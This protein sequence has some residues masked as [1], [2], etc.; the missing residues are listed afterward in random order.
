[1]KP[2]F[3]ELQWFRLANSTP[4]P[5]FYEFK[6]RFL[7]RFAVF[8]GYAIQRIPRHCWTCE[9]TGMYSEDQECRSCGGDGIYR[10]SE[11][12][13]ECWRLGDATYHRPIEPLPHWQHD[14]ATMREEIHGRIQHAPVSSKVAR[15]AFYR[16]L[17]RFEP[18]HFFF[19]VSADVKRQ[20]SAWRA[21]HY[22]R[23][24]KLRDKLDLFPAVE[25][26]DS[27]P[28]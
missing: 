13:L 2:N 7:R 27:V 4:A 12:W 1:M 26:R 21:R 28:F 22:W 3:K 15:R 17:L 6:D 11:H 25:D 23:L 14:G 24:M 16:L 10:V 19:Q 8:D 5:G 20:L 18:V 9:G